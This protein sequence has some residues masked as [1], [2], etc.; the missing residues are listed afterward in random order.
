MS[1]NV[2][3]MAKLEGADQWVAV[4][5][6][7][8]N[9]TSNTGEMISAVCGMSIPDMDKLSAKKALPVLKKG[10]SALSKNPEAFRQYEPENKWGTVET[11]LAFL[12]K[13]AVQCEEF[14]TSVME[15]SY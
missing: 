2:D 5:E 11:T 9:L 10:I 14:P 1:Y 13:L 6:Q 7:G 8:I 4:G 3:F 15:V 12:K